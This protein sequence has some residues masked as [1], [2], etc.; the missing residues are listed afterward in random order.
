[1]VAFCLL[2]LTFGAKCIIMGGVQDFCF[3]DVCHG[4]PEWQDVSQ[5]HR[6]FMLR[7]SFI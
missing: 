1:M 6:N 3:L 5:E 4:V 2:S 7:Q